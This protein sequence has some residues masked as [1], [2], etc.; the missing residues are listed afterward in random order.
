MS[1]WGQNQGYDE[2]VCTK[3]VGINTNACFVLHFGFQ[4]DN[5]QQ[6]SPLTQCYIELFNVYLPIALQTIQ[7]LINNSKLQNV[8]CPIG[9]KIMFDKVL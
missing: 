9:L 8:C 3:Y 4:K 7:D 2:I 1:H 6:N 5:F